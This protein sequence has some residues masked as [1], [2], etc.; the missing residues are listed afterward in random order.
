VSVRSARYNLL[1]LRRPKSNSMQIIELDGWAFCARAS[2]TG[3]V[4]I[5]DFR[6]QKAVIALVR[7]MK[8]AGV[9]EKMKAVYPFVGGTATTHMFNLKDPR[10]A[11]AA[12]RLSFLG[13]WTHSD[14]GALGNGTT[15]YADTF[16]IPANNLTAY[17]THISIYIRN[18]TL[19]W[20]DM[21]S[22]NN[23]QPNNFNIGARFG[24]TN[25]FFTEH[26]DYLNNFVYNT[27]TDSRGYF[28]T[29]R[30]ANNSMKLFK[31]A[32]QFG[33]TVT[34]I[35]TNFANLTGKMWIGRELGDSRYTNRQY[36]FSTIG[37]GLTDANVTA[38]QS[39]VQR[40]QTSLGR[41]V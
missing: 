26:Y 9:Y 5:R 28:L 6:Q 8:N 34:S 35:A 13:G 24:T 27:N 23:N 11:N 41:Q 20:K 19:F 31:N 14:N 32:T 39:I 18:D 7:D 3:Q 22:F 33:S 1:Q 17:S 36:A 2:T 40:F 37:D 4:G 21:S 16:L 25:L 15:S 30:T 10:D 29:S 38:L 12:Y